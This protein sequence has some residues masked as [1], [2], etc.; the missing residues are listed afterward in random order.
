MDLGKAKNPRI[1]FQFYAYPGS[2]SKLQ[3]FLDVNGQYRKLASEIDY[4]TLTGN[5]GWRTVNVDCAD[6]AFKKKKMV[7]GRVSHSRYL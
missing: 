6:A 2:K 4:S 5:V 1:S 7:M 3:V